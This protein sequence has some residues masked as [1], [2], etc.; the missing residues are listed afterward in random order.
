MCIW[1]SNRSDGIRHTYLIFRPKLDSF[2]KE[3]RKKNVRI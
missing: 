1:C 3:S 2:L